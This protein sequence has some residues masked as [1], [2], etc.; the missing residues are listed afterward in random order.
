MFDYI[1]SDLLEKE[2][3]EYNEYEELQLNIPEIEIKENVQEKINE[4][5]GV[6]VIDYY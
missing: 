5:R 4:E 1:I 2:K 6:I 3:K